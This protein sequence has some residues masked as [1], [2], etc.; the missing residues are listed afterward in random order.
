M[1]PR[2]TNRGWKSA[3]TLAPKHALLGTWFSP[4]CETQLWAVLSQAPRLIE[5]TAP[6]SLAR[7]QWAPVNGTCRTATQSSSVRLPGGR[8][9]TWLYFLFPL[10]VIISQVDEFDFPEPT[11]DMCAKFRLY[12]CAGI[13]QLKQ[14]TQT[15]RQGGEAAI[16]AAEKQPELA[17]QE[18]LAENAFFQ[19]AGVYN[20]LEIADAA[21]TKCKTARR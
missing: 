17:A 7:R 16:R 20:C 11:S 8:R 2:T 4:T 13:H 18:K 5:R 21:V 10:L 15:M 6:H 19:E 1:H 14:L 3:V 9:A 12:D